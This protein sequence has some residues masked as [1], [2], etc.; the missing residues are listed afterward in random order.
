MSV[1]VGGTKVMLVNV[2]GEIYAVDE[3]C[4]HMQC[5]LM[6]G[7]L[8]GKAVSCPCHDAAFDLA[9]GKLLRGPAIQDLPTY[10]VKIVKGEIHVEEKPPEIL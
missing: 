8:N 10:K 1:W 3:Q 7:K 5:S 9:T 2:E 4:T 6:T